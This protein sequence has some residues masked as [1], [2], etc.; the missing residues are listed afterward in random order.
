MQKIRVEHQAD[1]LTR[2]MLKAKEL[3]TSGNSEVEKK[4][5][6]NNENSQ[7]IS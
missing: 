3:E 1:I 7:N 5:T 6:E 2:A 4:E